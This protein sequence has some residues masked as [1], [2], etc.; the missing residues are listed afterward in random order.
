MTLT[1]FHNKFGDDIIRVMKS[2]GLSYDDAQDARQTL[3]Q[4]MINQN[5]EI[6]DDASHRFVFV[7]SKNQAQAFSDSE[8]NRK[9]KEVDIVYD[10]NLENKTCTIE[11]FETEFELSAKNIALYNKIIKLAEAYYPWPNVCMLNILNHR[12]DGLSYKEIGNKFGI[13]GSTIS[14]AVKTWR[15]RLDD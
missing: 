12:V 9:L 1:Q 4:R 7:I 14:N 13:P 8:R 15:K 11:C 6:R 2:C 10:M 5:T 3:Y